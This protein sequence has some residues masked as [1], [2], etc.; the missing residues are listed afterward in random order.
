MHD[1]GRDDGVVN[2]VDVKVNRRGTA[3]FTGEGRSLP[4]SGGGLRG[5]RYVGVE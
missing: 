4:S 1:V 3:S 5:C 2:L